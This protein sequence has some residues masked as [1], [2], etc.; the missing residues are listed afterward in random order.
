MESEVRRETDQT[1]FDPATTA[2]LAESLSEFDS[3]ATGKNRVPIN[4]RPR[5]HR[6]KS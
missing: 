4:K 5:D 3:G 2:N 6:K 1:N